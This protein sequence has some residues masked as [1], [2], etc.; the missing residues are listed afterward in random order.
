MEWNWSTIT[1]YLDRFDEKVA[2]NVA[3]L[4]PHGT[5]RMAVM[6]TDNRAPT[7]D[8]LDKMR[9]LVDQCMREGAVGL[10]TGLTYTPGMYAT[11]DEIVELCKSIRPYRGLLLPASSQLWD[12]RDS[13]VQRF[14]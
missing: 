7:D 11:D 5:V 13:G 8:E 3:M 6:G 14:D 12:A 4:V 1:E 9:A 10:S 2:V